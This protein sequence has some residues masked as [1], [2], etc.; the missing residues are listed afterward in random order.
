VTLVFRQL[1]CKLGEL[2]GSVFDAIHALSLPHVEE[3][4]D[5]LFDFTRSEDLDAWLKE[6][7]TPDV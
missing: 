7:K 6:H 4:G 5:A 2:P 3:L 1:A